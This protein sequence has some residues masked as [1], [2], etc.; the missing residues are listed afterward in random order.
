MDDAFNGFSLHALTV[1]HLVVDIMLVSLYQ[2]M[3]VGLILMNLIMAVFRSS[4]QNVMHE[5]PLKI[6]LRTSMLTY[7]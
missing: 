1:I 5:T 4:C 3:E 6:W 2:A 7:G